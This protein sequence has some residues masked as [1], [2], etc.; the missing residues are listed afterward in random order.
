MRGVYNSVTDIRR[1]VFTAIADMAYSDYPDYAKRIE[2]IPYEIRS[3]KDDPYRNDIFLERAIIGERLRLGMGLPLRNVNEAGAISDGIEESTIA[4]KYYDAPL[5]NII[6]FACNG[7]P[8]KKVMVTTACQGCLSHQCTEVCPRDAIHIVNGHSLIDQDKCIKCGRCMDACPYHAIVKMERPCAASCGMN[9]ISTDENGKAQIDYDK[10]VSCGMCLVNCPFG[11]IVD[12]GQIFQ[13]IYA[14]KEGYEVIAAVAPAFVGQFGPQMTIGKV[15]NALKMLG[16]SDVVEVAVGADLCTIDEAQDFM[17]NVPKNLDF[18][19]TSCCPAWSV[20]A[21][22]EFP[23]F[24]KN[25]SMALTPMVLTGR[26]IKKEHPDAK[27]VFIGPCAAKKLEASRRSVR[28]DIDF[29]LTFEE[30]MGMF[31]AKHINPEEVEEDEKSLKEGTKAGRQ[32]AVSGGVAASVKELIEKEHPGTKVNVQAAEGLKNCKTMLMMAKAGR[33]NG[34]L[35]EGMA[36]PGGCVGGAG[37][38]QPIPK[39]SALVKKYAK[40]DAKLF[41]DES[42]YSDRVEELVKG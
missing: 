31:E 33:L 21:K 40:D 18:M 19:G 3:G 8:E 7:C 28:S 26:L 14:M 17:E 29:V 20:M 23:Q 1:K 35:L 39:S 38:L 41:A 6:K 5:I 24:A 27:V 30:V 22:K 34:Y 13:T 12:K 42:K 11:A 2:E 32:F 16:F 36:C 37:T 9:A 15:K 10:C 4:R 25:I